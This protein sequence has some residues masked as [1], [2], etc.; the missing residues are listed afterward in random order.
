LLRG[1][2]LLPGEVRQQILNERKT[3]TEIEL[4]EL[5]KQRLAHELEDLWARRLDVGQSAVREARNDLE[6]LQ[7]HGR[8]GLEEI[9]RIIARDVDRLNEN[10]IAIVD[11]FVRR[12]RK[13]EKHPTG[14]LGITQEET[15]PVGRQ[16][17]LDLQKLLGE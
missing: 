1:A 16:L 8:V 6:H 17:I 3:Q 12:Y 11:V 4:K 13:G 5:E 9:E 7:H 10:E 2:L 15:G 14:A